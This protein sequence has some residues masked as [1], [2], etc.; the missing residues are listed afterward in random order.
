MSLLQQ[1]FYTKPITPHNHQSQELRRCLTATDLIFMGVGAI[2]GA[3]IFVLTGIA[4]ATEAGPGI[5]LSYLLAGL[6]C[7][8]SAFAYAELASSIGGS[9]SAYGYAYAGLGQ[10]IA[11][12]IGW[13][14][15][16]EYGM[17]AA[18]VSIGWSGYIQDAF[19][20]FGIT[21][22]KILTNDPFH[23]GI[24]NLPAV[25]IVAIIGTILSIGVKESATVNKIIVF[26]KL[27]VIL[28]FIVIGSFYFKSDNWHP[29]LPFGAQGIVNGAGLIFFAY[30]GFDAVSTAADEAISPQRDLPRGIIGSLILCTVLYIIVAGLLTG[31]THYSNLNVTSP[32][33]DVL[34]RLGHNVSAEIVSLGAIAGLTTVILV[35]YYGFTRVFLA[36]AKDGLLPQRLTTIHAKSKTPR[37]LIITMG[38]LIA[39]SAGMIPIND[40]AEIVNI[41][42]LS[43]FAVVCAGVIVLRYKKPDMERPF[44]TPFS[45]FIPILGIVFCVYLMLSL[46]KTTWLCFAIWTICGLFIYMFYSRPNSFK[47]IKK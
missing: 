37:K 25:V 45:P 16:L 42:T 5:I 41:G 32:V 26:I 24:V 38:I 33:S 14:L 43:A 9:G 8:F 7:G 11:W 19:R 27:A 36:M 47:Y 46:P 15:L 35:M 6:A 29:F 10:L 30:I 20:A 13:D 21:L 28:F 34:L 22:P 17:D 12:I 3:G 40:I 23:G 1:F 18:T 4:A 44:K 31:M 2:I 39:I